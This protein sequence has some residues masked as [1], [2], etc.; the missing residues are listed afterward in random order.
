M[1]CCTTRRRMGTKYGYKLVIHNVQ[2]G[3]STRIARC[4]TI[5]HLSLYFVHYMY[6]IQ[7]LLPSGSRLEFYTGAMG[8]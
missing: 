4:R 7:Q 3:N 6:K 2:A 8:L 5:P 1:G